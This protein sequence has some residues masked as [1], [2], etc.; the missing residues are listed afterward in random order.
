MNTRE[1]AK[2]IGLVGKYCVYLFLLSLIFVMRA[3]ATDCN[4]DCSDACLTSWRYPCGIGQWCDETAGVAWMER[5]A[6]QEVTAA[7]RPGNRSAR[8]RLDI[9]R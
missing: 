8:P 6:I 7:T 3:G 2:R 4:T 1:F 9:L 5:S